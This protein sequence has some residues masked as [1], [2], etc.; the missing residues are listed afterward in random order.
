MT[1]IKEARSVVDFF[2]A[3]TYL[4]A[5]LS[6]ATLIVSAYEGFG[7]SILIVCI[8]AK[9]LIGASSDDRNGK[10]DSEAVNFPRRPFPARGWRA[11]WVN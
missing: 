9:I 7:F 2:V 1:A 8:L 6:I 10:T 4:S 3:L 5:L 11:V